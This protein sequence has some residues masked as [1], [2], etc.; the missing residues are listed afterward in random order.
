[1]G[2]TI[3]TDPKK[4]LVECWH[5]GRGHNKSNADDRVAVETI[6]V[7]HHHNACDGQDSSNDLQRRRET[8][9]GVCDQRKMDGLHKD[10]RAFQIRH[11]WPPLGLSTT[12]S[13]A[14]PDSNCQGESLTSAFYCAVSTQRTTCSTWK[15]RCKMW[16]SAIWKYTVWIVYSYGNK[17]CLVMNN[18]S[19]SVFIPIQRTTATPHILC[20]VKFSTKTTG[21]L[22]W[23]LG[24]VQM[25][26]ASLVLPWLPDIDFLALPLCLH[27][28]HAYPLLPP[29]PFLCNYSNLK[30]T[31][32]SFHSA[33]S[34]QQQ[35]CCLCFIILSLLLCVLE[36]LN[37][38]V[39]WGEPSGAEWI[40]SALRR[41]QEDGWALWV[42]MVE[43][44]QAPLGKVSFCAA[45]CLSLT[46]TCSVLLT[47]CLLTRPAR[48]AASVQT[49]LLSADAN[50]RMHLC[51]LV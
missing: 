27:S 43:A 36:C 44:L 25:Q 49:V 14:L 21:R 50:G 34:N 46:C 15:T 18:I 39:C 29:T 35:A 1:M 2:I 51:H 11:A 40:N 26:A 3:L 20:K 41:C 32:N 38:W 16:M 30:Q 23:R 42:Y 19:L 45:G 6:S 22:H 4:Y 9:E 31:K 48:V 17:F 24:F 33:V 7:G 37:W 13:G 12:K 5:R 10:A 28:K 8:E 47:G